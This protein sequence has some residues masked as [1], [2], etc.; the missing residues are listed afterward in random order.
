MTDAE[1]RKLQEETGR[2]LDRGES[3]RKRQAAQPKQEAPPKKDPSAAARKNSFDALTRGLLAAR[4]KRIDAVDAEVRQQKAALQAE[5]AREGLRIDTYQR[6]PVSP[7]RQVLE[8]LIPLTEL[9]FNDAAQVQGLGLDVEVVADWKGTLSLSAVDAV[10]IRTEQDRLH[11]EG[12]QRQQDERA[13][14]LAHE[15]KRQEVYDRAYAEGIEAAKEEWRKFRDAP[16]GDW[17]S[18]DAV[19]VR[20]P[21]HAPDGGFSNWFDAARLERI[22]PVSPQQAARARQKAAEALAAFDAKETN[23]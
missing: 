18:V 7:P 15:R 14:E 9:G 17:A 23:R 10:R 19:Q 13:A 3:E 2:R 1:I 20:V 12:I 16:G 11:L 5:A 21:E 8:G 4:R 22:A 6:G